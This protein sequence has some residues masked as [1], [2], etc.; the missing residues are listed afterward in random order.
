MSRFGTYNVIWNNCQDFLQAF[1]DRIISR[2]AEDWDWFR[3]YTKTEYQEHQALKIPTPEA[4]ITAN[5]AWREAA[6]CVHAHSSGVGGDGESAGAGAVA[7][8]DGGAAAAMSPPM[9]F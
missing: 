4:I 9:G 1:A 3:E 8:V 7:A 6:R 2:R 5:R